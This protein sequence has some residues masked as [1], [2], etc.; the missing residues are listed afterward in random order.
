MVKRTFSK[1]PDPTPLR[2]LVEASGAD[3]NDPAIDMSLAEVF[4]YLGPATVGDQALLGYTLALESIVVTAMWRNSQLDE[5]Y[6]ILDGTELK[7]I[8]MFC[9]LWKTDRFQK[10]YQESVRCEEAS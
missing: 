3:F 7:C 6:L 10:A 8:G 1:I 5:E 9:A 4:D 2:R